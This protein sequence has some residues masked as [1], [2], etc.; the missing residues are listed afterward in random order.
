MPL[1]VDALGRPLL[2]HL[3]HSGRGKGSLLNSASLTPKPPAP[4]VYL[5]VL[6]APSAL[7]RSI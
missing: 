7:K 3:D 1:T 4:S 2:K 6:K 5:H